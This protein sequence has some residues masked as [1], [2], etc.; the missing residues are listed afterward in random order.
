[1]PRTSDDCQVSGLD[2]EERGGAGND[3][4]GKKIKIKM[5]K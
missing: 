5:E 3:D 1:M 2:Y 4:K